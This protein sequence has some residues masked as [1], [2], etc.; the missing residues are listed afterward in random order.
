MLK[1]TFIILL[2]GLLSTTCKKKEDET[3]AFPY[4]EE[5]EDICD[6]EILLEIDMYVNSSNFKDLDQNHWKS[7]I[8]DYFII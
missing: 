1:K 4:E 5:F 7:I 3:T 8:E 2:I 6:R